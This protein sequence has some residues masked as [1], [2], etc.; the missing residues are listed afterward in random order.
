M[1]KRELISSLFLSAGL[2]LAGLTAAHADV[3]DNIEQSGTIRI[4]TDLGIPPAGMLTPDMKPTG[5]DVEVGQALAKDWGLK[6]ELVQTTG[7]TRIPNLQNDKA[8]IVV[9]TLSVTPERAKVIDFSH[10]Y[11]VLQSIVAGGPGL[12]VSSL[13]TLK[14]HTVSVTRGTT[15]DTDLTRKASKYGFK[16]ARYD[17]DATLVTAA[18]TGQAKMVATSQSLVAQIDK[19]IGKNNFKPLFVLQNFDLAIGVKKGEKR[20]LDKVN[21]WVDA[22]IKNGRLNAIHKKFYGNELPE[23]MRGSK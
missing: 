4:A 2:A 17:D 3:L 13:E 1:K 16:V 9:S 6:Y 12:D 14:D 11:A 22:N 8:D 15:Q 18:V 7:A 21:A 10:R 5:A 20:L 19:K 23:D